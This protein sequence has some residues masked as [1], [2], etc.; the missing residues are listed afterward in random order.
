MWWIPLGERAMRGDPRGIVARWNHPLLCGFRTREKFAMARP[1][2]RDSRS[3]R[4]RAEEC[5]SIAETFSNPQTRARM[6]RMAAD[7]E[8]LAELA[9][10]REAALA[11]QPALAVETDAGGRGAGSRPAGR[12]AAG[13]AADGT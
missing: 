2:H 12:G 5:R 8:R 9:E 13:R 1:E 11:A 3:W 4:A 10:Q 6:F 7:Y